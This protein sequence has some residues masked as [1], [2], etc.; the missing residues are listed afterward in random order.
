MGNR[1]LGR[2][3]RLALSAPRLRE[4]YSFEIEAPETT[5]SPPWNHESVPASAG[6]VRNALP[7]Y[8]LT[9]LA[10][11]MFVESEKDELLARHRSERGMGTPIMIHTALLGSRGKVFPAKENVRLAFLFIYDSLWIRK[12][13]AD[14]SPKLFLIAG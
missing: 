2:A 14:V 4:I 11:R 13:R 10:E 12:I 5:H 7:H 6:A 9:G 8:P 1:R 3:F